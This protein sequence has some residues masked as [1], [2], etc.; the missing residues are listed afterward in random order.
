MNKIEPRMNNSATDLASFPFIYVL[1]GYLA[2]YLLF[3]IYPV[4]LNSYH[5]YLCYCGVPREQTIGCDGAH[6]IK[7]SREVFVAHK[8]PYIS[9][10]MYPPLTYV[11]FAP[12]ITVSP[13]EAY[14]IKTIVTII[15]YFFTGFILP[16]WVNSRKSLSP[17][18]IFLL[19]TGLSSYGFQ[20]EMERGQFNVLAM[21]F[22]L[23][24]IWIYH[25]HHRYRYLAYFLFSLS[26][27]LKVYPA[28][29]I[30]LLIRD[31][32]D[33]KNNIM[34][35]L[36][37]GVFNFAL[38]FVLGPKIFVDFVAKL[39]ASGPTVWIGNHSIEAFSQVF[40]MK[41]SMWTK[42]DSRLIYILLFLLV[43][44]CIFL[45]VLQAYRQKYNGINPY[46]LLAC[47]LGAMLIP[48]EGNDYKLSILVAPVAIA[49]HNDY[50]AK[51]FNYR[52]RLLIS[53]LMVV[54]FFAY[55][56]T[57]YTFIIKQYVILLLANNFPALMVM[58]LI[59]T[60][61]SLMNKS[62]HEIQAREKQ[63]VQQTIDLSI[64][65]TERRKRG[66]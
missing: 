26:I 21:F 32:R 49:F 8:T 65:K 5:G 33:W 55:S 19:A 14:A 16:L 42:E 59:T 66:R 50:F 61:F 22:C 47:T 7:C 10:N 24:S 25:Y 48:F 56:L 44:V 34:R 53:I 62:G 2:V 9:T 40:E 64:T 39:K 15:C 51:I 41:Y 57:L 13:P 20:F 45:I 37:L 23:V 63:A 52:S 3:F 29:F 28:I 35:F 54:F 1:S 31:W 17:F 43:A 36:G 6:V 30:L 60:A 46:L 18:L 58:L 38:L 27:Q 11:F 12:L 4:F